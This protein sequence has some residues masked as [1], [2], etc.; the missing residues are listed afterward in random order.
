MRE[1]LRLKKP[2]K[3]VNVIRE[4]EGLPVGPRTRQTFKFVYVHYPKSWTFNAT[5]GFLPRI[6]KVEARPGLN[7]CKKNGSLAL[8]LARVTEMGGTTLDPKDSRLGEYQDYVHFYPLRGGGKYYVDFNK[9]AVVLPNDEVMWNNHEQRDQWNEF[10]VH[11][12]DCGMIRPI[13]KEVYLSMLERE[14]KKANSLSGRVDRNPHLA[15]KLKTSLARVEAMQDSWNAS[16]K[17]TAD[18]MAQAKKPAKRIAKKV[19]T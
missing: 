14:R 18:M 17:V 16:N 13:L 11:L 4:D 5:L 8:T 12:R 7:G 10:M 15:N 2:T 3:E 6:K 9:E 19:S 1:T